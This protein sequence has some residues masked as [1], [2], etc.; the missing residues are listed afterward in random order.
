MGSSRAYGW[1]LGA[2]SLGVGALAAV[3]DAPGAAVVAGL[4]GLAAGAIGGSDAKGWAAE[5]A[6]RHEAEAR[7]EELEAA[8]ADAEA[9][10]AAL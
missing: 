2:A 9:R 6:R 1:S 4:C 8:V 10:A 3:A 5:E 7:S